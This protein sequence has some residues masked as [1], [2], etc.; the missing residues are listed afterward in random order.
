MTPNFARC[1]LSWLAA[2]ALP[3]IA[4]PQAPASPNASE[5]AH[6]LT[7]VVRAHANRCHALYGECLAEAQTM[8]ATITSMLAE[9]SAESLTTARAAWTKARFAY[10]RTETLRFSDGP[11]EPLEPLLNSWPVDE[12]Y[13]DYVQGNAT[14]GIVH[15]RDHYPQLSQTVLTLANERSGEANISVGWHA[16]EFLLWGQDLRDAGPGDRPFTD[17]VVGKGPDADRRRE[18]LMCITDLLVQQFESLVAEW[19]PGTNN[20]RHRF[21]ADPK[22]AIRRMLTGALVLTAFEL[23]GERMAVAYETK[24]QEQ[25]H[26]CFSDTSCQ[27]FVADQLGIVQMFQP[28]A[29]ATTQPGLLALIA[30]RDERLARS[31]WSQ[32]ED[33]LAKMR[34]IPSPFDQAMRGADDTPGRIAIRAALDA[35]DAQAELLSIAGQTFGFELPVHPGGR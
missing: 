33:T 13:I 2:L 31:L 21:E 16:I 19:A 17:Y 14:A 3:G 34:A 23:G 26:S 5:Q 22:G 6:L 24:D 9:P 35:L 27:D 1:F 32:L 7:T 4:R 8:R 18:Y 25:E 15:D 20:Y 11:I 29:D 10:C 12:A 28:G 30:A